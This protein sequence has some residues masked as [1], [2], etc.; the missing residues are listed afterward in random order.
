[1]CRRCSARRA[2]RC[3]CR[4]SPWLLAVRVGVLRRRRARLWRA[5]SSRRCS[6]SMSRSMR[7]TPVLLQLFVLYYGS[8]ASCGC[9]PS[10]PRCSGSASTTRRTNRE[11]YRAALEAIARPQ[12]E[13]ARTLGPHRIPDP[14][15]RAR[16][17]GVAARAGADD[18]R[19][20]RAAQGF[21]ARLGDHRRRAHEADGDFR[22]ELGSWVVPGLLC[23]LGVPR[24]VAA[25]L[26]RRAH[27]ERRWSATMTLAR[28]PRPPRHAR[29]D[30]EVLRGV[31]LDVAP[32]E[33][34]AL[35]G[36]WCAGR[37]PCCAAVAALQAF[38]AGTIAV[39]DVML[40]AG[41]CRPQSQLGALRRHVGMVF[42]AHALFEHLTALDNVTLAPIHALRWDRARAESV[43]RELLE[44]LGVG[45]RASALPR[46]LRAAKPS[47][48][49]L[50]A[51]S[52]R[53]RRCC[54][55][56]NRPRRS[57]RRAAARSARRCASSRRQ[58]G[59]SSFDARRRLRA[60][61]RRS[62]HHAGRGTH[63]QRRRSVNVCNAR[64][65]MPSPLRWRHIT[66]EHSNLLGGRRC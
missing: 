27:L 62:R 15:A 44:S 13:A 12:L 50:R 3:C 1:M 26:A 28:R 23:A 19:L 64:P 65:P 36:L 31:D 53:I 6:R 29:H 32:G 60:R 16:A 56:T 37:P 49:R 4:A 66:A 63:H 45:T 5:G 22:D 21:V 43:A 9:R 14:A 35:M 17:A 2:S 40:R 58:G 38:D 24:D 59:R 41:P 42:Q 10:P 30:R 18:E 57:T 20:R 46:Q 25:A 51:R 39:D 33:I 34:C 55:W 48:S 7:G 52:P 47:A 11:I 54:S 8:R 61:L